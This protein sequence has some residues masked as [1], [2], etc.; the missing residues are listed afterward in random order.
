MKVEGTALP[1]VLLIEPKVFGDRRGYFFEAWNAERYR[2]AG[3]DVAFVQDNLSFSERGV[4]RGLHCQHPH[5]QGKLVQVLDGEVFDVVVDIRRGS[6]T[7]GKSFCTY[8]SSENRCQ[9]YVP[10]G[11]AHG[12]CVTS[13]RALFSYKCTDLYHP[14]SEFTVLWN[15]PDLGI[16]WPAAEPSLSDKDLKGIRLRDLPSTRLPVF[17][18]P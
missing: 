2:E 7:F 10:A 17:E 16:D 14:A 4:L 1:G 13:A 6:P 15:D 3:V 11:F 8:L 18:V 9:L 5:A 12:F